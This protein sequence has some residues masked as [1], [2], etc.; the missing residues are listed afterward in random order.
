MKK[1]VAIV[2]SLIIFI[3]YAMSK[4]RTPNDNENGKVYKFLSTID[5]EPATIPNAYEFSELPLVYGGRLKPYDT[6]AR[7]ALRVISDSEN[8]YEKTTLDKLSGIKHFFYDLFGW[9]PV[10]KV[11]PA[12]WLL[13]TISGN[14]R[15]NDYRCFR[16]YNLELIEK[17]GLPDRSKERYK[18][19]PAEIYA[20]TEIEHNH[21]DGHSHK[22][23]RRQFV[24]EEAR[25]ASE[26]DVKKRNVY[27][28]S[29][30]S[31]ATKIN[32]Y[33]HLTISH[34]TQEVPDNMVVLSYNQLSQFIG[35]NSPRP[36]PTEKGEWESVIF[37]NVRKFGGEDSTA[38]WNGM[39]D[40]LISWQKDDYAAFN[41]ALAGFKKISQEN[42]AQTKQFLDDKENAIN[43]RETNIGKELAG[44]SGKE[45]QETRESVLTWV[46][47]S[48]SYLKSQRDLWGVALGK[49]S[50]E[51]FF[52][53]MSPFYVSMAFYVMLF[54]ISCFGLLFWREHFWKAAFSGFVI[55]FLVH[56]FAVWC[57]WY[58]SGYP[59]VT[60][61]YSSA[62]FIGWGVALVG[63]V[64]ELMYK[65]FFGII[66][67]AIA[68]YICLFI[69]VNLSGDGDTMGTMVAVL[70]TKFW[71]ATHVI[72][73]TLGYTATFLA[74]GIGLVWIVAKL[75]KGVTKQFDKELNRA[76]YGVICYGM[77]LS[78]VG[79]VLGGL[80]ADDSWGRFWGW[81][82]KENGALMIVLWNAVILHAKWAHSIKTRGLA[83]LCLFGNVVTAWSWFGTNLLSVGLHSYGFTSSGAF[84]LGL[85]AL[86][87]L[88]LV[89]L[90]SIPL[91][92]W[93]T[94]KEEE[95]KKEAPV[96]AL[97]ENA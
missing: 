46:Y 11:P 69:S 90:C 4:A 63:I 49:M 59:P 74:G 89:I 22:V 81:D 72:T 12:V 53:H 8:I 56:T 77:F 15:K 60:N 61:L 50:F 35:S 42:I 43:D 5:D 95:S 96:T 97:P 44:L 27:Q 14:E 64:L 67:S 47:N 24:M 62:I 92:C 38:I 16:V 2:I 79:T 66:V 10:I 55:T 19:T 86:I 31:L 85:F 3:G 29:V 40:M 57:R 78:F 13:D 91:N 51:R 52:N 34:L 9:D 23:T 28:T 54:I 84:W 71:L 75:F 45:L 82:P 6:L 32:L 88:L 20:E 58:I 21:G 26:V 39:R 73:I 83:A 30:L 65:R 94:F 48:K 76:M 87:H 18:Y 25:S 41:D 70:D 36:I 68:G 33:D 37:M 1:Y 80:W 93:N 17:L 7:N